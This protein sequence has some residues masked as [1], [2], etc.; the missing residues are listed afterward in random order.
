MKNFPVKVNGKEYWISRS[1]AVCVFIFRLK[2]NT[3]EV[4][5]E[6][7]GAGVDHSGERCA[8]CGYL[9]YDQTLKGA[10]VAE[11]FQETGM[12]IDANRLK[13]VGYGDNPFDSDSYKQNVSMHF[14]YE[15][16]E[17]EDINPSIR[18]GGEENEVE[19]IEWI[20]VNS[21]PDDFCFNH[22]KLI[23]KYVK[24]TNMY[25]QKRS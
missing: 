17:F 21:L 24:Y 22:K 11:T 10:C 15:T 4:L 14:I 18:F 16:N 8:V 19:K 2:E 12:V 1:I 9:E 20:N 23:E 25:A 6:I 5:T 3:I 13:F 7:R